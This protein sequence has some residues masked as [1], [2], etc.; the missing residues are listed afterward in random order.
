VTGHPVAAFLWRA[1]RNERYS[2]GAVVFP[3]H[4]VVNVLAAGC[5]FE[6]PES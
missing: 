2:Y 1:R 6:I 4:G 5:Y 3:F